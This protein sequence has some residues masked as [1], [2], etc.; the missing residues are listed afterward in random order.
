MFT[1]QSWHNLAKY[2]NLLYSRSFFHSLFTL[3][4]LKETS[5][6]LNAFMNVMVVYQLPYQVSSLVLRSRQCVCAKFDVWIIL[7]VESSNMWLC[8]HSVCSGNVQ[9]WE[10]VSQ[11]DLLWMWGSNSE[12]SR[13][14]SY[15]QTYWY[16]KVS[17]NPRGRGRGDA[18]NTCVNARLAGLLSL[19]CPL[20]GQCTELTRPVCCDLDLFEVVVCFDLRA[21]EY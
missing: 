4:C 20:T 21:G 3:I 10:K 13:A 18:M 17:R 8:L 5:A 11:R 19:Y 1:P 16:V 7:G 12:T 2:S 6:Y 14:W 9:I 15:W